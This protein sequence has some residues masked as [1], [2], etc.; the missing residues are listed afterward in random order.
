MDSANSP[1]IFLNL[2]KSTVKA[3]MPNLIHFLDYSSSQ[4]TQS[5]LDICRNVQ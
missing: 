3:L 1:Q 5:K 2:I 4:V